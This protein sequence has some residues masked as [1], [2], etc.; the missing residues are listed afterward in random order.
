M[1][2][3]IVVEDGTG[4]ANANSYISVGDADAYQLNRGRSAWAALDADAKS[5]ALIQATEFVD[6]TFAWI[7]KRKT[8]TQ[9]LK[10]P[11]IYGLDSDGVEIV[12]TDSDGFEITGVPSVIPK[13]VA[14]A[15]F[16]SLDNNLFQDSDP[17][18]KII[19]KKTDVLETE[20]QP[21]SPSLKPSA[22]TIFGAINTM[23]RGLYFQPAG[24]MVV[25]KAVRG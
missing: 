17:R 16:L 11:R 20:Y 12:L 1:A 23:L 7:G 9:A 4:I 15:A 18:G 8:S 19:R 13:S 3:T 25:G 5:S 24:G 2:I 6:S 10:W 14:E 22:P 21:E